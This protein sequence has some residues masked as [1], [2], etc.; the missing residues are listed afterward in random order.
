MKGTKGRSA[1]TMHGVHAGG[2][3]SPC[4]V[5]VSR[6]KSFRV[7]TQLP[8]SHLS[9]RFAGPGGRGRVAAVAVGIVA[10]RASRLGGCQA[11]PPVSIMKSAIAA[12]GVEMVYW[13]LLYLSGCLPAMLAVAVIALRRRKCHGMD[14]RATVQL[15]L[16]AALAWPLLAVAGVQ[17]IGLVAVAKLPSLIRGLASH[18][19][20]TAADVASASVEPVDRPAST[21]L[22]PARAA[23]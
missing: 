1:P 20:G 16:L 12:G 18:G 15:T 14:P 6:L 21:S 3:A 10:S 23:A 5:D 13:L 9:P 4:D 8:G 17:L 11:S 19:A 7:R 22:E 2:T